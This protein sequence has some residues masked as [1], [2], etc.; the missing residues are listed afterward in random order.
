MARASSGLPIGRSAR[1]DGRPVRHTTRARRGIVTRSRMASSISTR[2]RSARITIDVRGRLT[3]ASMSS[4]S[5]VKICW[6][7]PS[8]R[9]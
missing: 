4:A 3:P 6:L 9:T 5:T 8:T 2:S 7:Q 1:S